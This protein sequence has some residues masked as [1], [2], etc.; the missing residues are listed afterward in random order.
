MNIRRLSEVVWR[1]RLVVSAV[2]LAGIALFLWAQTGLRKYVATSTVL[3]ATSNST[4]T[5]VLDPL[6]D[7]TSAAVAP[8]DLPNLLTSMRVI[9][10]V[11]KDLHVPEKEEPSL[12]GRIKAR[13]AGSDILPIS[14]TDRDP[15]R[16][17]EGANAVTKELVKYDQEIVTARYDQL[18]TDLT[19]QLAHRRD[20]LRDLD[21]RITALTAANPY[22]TTDQGNAALNVRLDALEAQRQ[23]IAAT[24]AGDAAAASTAAMRP[25]LV[26]EA[27]K[28]EIVLSDPEFQALRTQLG[29]DLAQLYIEKAGYTDK[30]PGLAGMQGQVDRERDSLNEEES[31]AASTPAKSPTYAAALL[32]VNKANAAL[33]NDRAQLAAID[34]QIADMTSRLQASEDETI[35]LAELRRDRLA[36]DQAYADLSQRLSKAIA[37]RAQAASIDSVVVIDLAH[38]ASPS[39]ISRPAVLGPAIGLAFVWLALTL[40]FILDAGDTRLRTPQ[41]IEDAYGRPVFHSVG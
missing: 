40:A 24:M 29:K 19:N 34:D 2:M 12:A 8:Q 1:Q 9:S 39:F 32:D 18:I 30:F 25:A 3:A 22:L 35:R 16:A 5:G 7:P 15:K 13:V 4:D 10:R 36:A 37:D 20:K 38:A 23:T 31:A 6:K 21:A 26:R 41:A 17:V 11:A 33:A 14:F 27:A 28:R